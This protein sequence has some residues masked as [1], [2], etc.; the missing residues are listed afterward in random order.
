MCQHWIVE[1]ALDL[2]LYSSP[3]F[4]RCT[5]FREI[6]CTDLRGG[7]VL[8]AQMCTGY[9][10]SVRL[11]SSAEYSRFGVEAGRSPSTPTS[12]AAV[13]SKVGKHI[14]S[15]PYQPAL[16]LPSATTTGL[17]FLNAGCWNLALTP[18]N[19]CIVLIYVRLFFSFFFPFLG[20]FLFFFVRCL[21]CSHVMVGNQ[22][23][24][25]ILQ[26]EKIVKAQRHIIV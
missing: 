21:K 10:E 26:V 5:P 23:G 22:I 4:L 15:E 7:A 3:P 20:C 16:L 14:A 1:L 25:V 17:R 19:L 2:T 24:K 13:L 12:V 11:P 6:P 9:W 18:V 8:H